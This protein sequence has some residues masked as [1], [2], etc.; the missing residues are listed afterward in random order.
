[1]RKKL[2]FQKWA[3]QF[4]NLLVVAIA[5]FSGEAIITTRA[6]PLVSGLQVPASCAL[7]HNTSAGTKIFI[8]SDLDP[9]LRNILGK[10]TSSTYS[11][12]C[13]MNTVP[14]PNLDPNGHTFTIGGITYDHIISPDGGNSPDPLGPSKFDAPTLSTFHQMTVNNPSQDK[15]TWNFANLHLPSNQ[16]FTFAIHTY[17]DTTKLNFKLNGGDPIV[18]LQTNTFQVVYSSKSGVNTIVLDFSGVSAGTIVQVGDF[19]VGHPS[20]Q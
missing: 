3:F 18:G 5:T 13:S 12:N 10:G 9:T 19:F 17:Q 1:M 7:E 8:R 16:K 2:N 4:L 20:I 6:A 15:V 14:A 11:L